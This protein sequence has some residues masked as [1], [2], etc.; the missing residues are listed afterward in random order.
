[1]MTLDYFLF[2]RAKTFAVNDLG[3]LLMRCELQCYHYNKEIDS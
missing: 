1:M 2:T 3:L